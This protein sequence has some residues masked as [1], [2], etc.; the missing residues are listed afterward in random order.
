VPIETLQTP[1]WMKLRDETKPVV[2]CNV[3]DDDPEWLRLP[4]GLTE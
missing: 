2:N 4:G 3:L 1:R